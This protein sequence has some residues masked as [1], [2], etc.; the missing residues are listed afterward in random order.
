[1]QPGIHLRRLQGG[2]AV[3][4]RLVRH[5]P[6]PPRRPPIRQPRRRDAPPA[7]R[8][9]TRRPPARCG[10]AAPGCGRRCAAHRRGATRSAPRRGDPPDRPAAPPG[11]AI[12]SASSHADGCAACAA[13]LHRPSA[14]PTT[15]AF[16]QAEPISTRSDSSE[17]ARPTSLRSGVGHHRSTVSQSPSRKP[18]RST[19]SER[20]LTTRKPSQ[21]PIPPTSSQRP[22]LAARVVTVPRGRAV[23]EREEHERGDGQRDHL[24]CQATD[25]ALPAGSAAAIWGR[26]VPTTAPP[27]A[28]A[29]IP[30]TRTGADGAIARRGS[31][32]A[33]DQHPHRHQR[34]AGAAR[35]R[36]DAG[37]SGTTSRGTSTSRMA[38]STR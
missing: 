9:R 27:S 4:D 20:R 37:R 6:S 31:H 32:V 2:E 26:I 28:K 3:H 24:A 11:V 16:V 36:A 18:I 30:P 12:S 10:R 35:C 22:T 21:P 29:A 14:R 33:R 38:S 15:A 23:Q 13:I 17:V 34:P 19:R 1:M 8:A 5:P 25:G 7:R